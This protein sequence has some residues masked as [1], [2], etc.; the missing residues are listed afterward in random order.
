MNY[1]AHYDR[2]IERAQN[3]ILPEGT[4][5]EKHHIVPVTMGGSNKKSNLV[6]LLPEEHLLAHLLLSRIY[7]D[8][9]GLASAVMRMTKRKKLI[10][11]KSYGTAR[12]AAAKRI[13]EHNSKLLNDRYSSM[14][15]EE[16]KVVHGSPGEKNPMFG[17]THTD[18]VKKKISEMKK[19]LVGEKHPHYGKTTKLKGKTYEEQFGKE[20]ADQLKKDRSEKLK[21][22]D[23]SHLRGENC[24]SKRADVRAKISAAKCVPVTV[25]G[26]TYESMQLACKELNISNWILKKMLRVQT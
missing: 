20:K 8:D 5:K 9:I 26:I 19:L 12:R 4:Y 16:R 14:T 25:N 1:Q 6:P 23:R 13:G 22:I 24:P 10:G 2:L 3:R 15:V 11:N 21:G 7:P 17:K 18:E